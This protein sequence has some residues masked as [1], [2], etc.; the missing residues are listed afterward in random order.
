MADDKFAVPESIID[1]LP[2]PVGTTVLVRV[3]DGPNSRL[4]DIPDAVRINAA[5]LATIGKVVSLG[6]DAY[7]GEAFAS[8]PYCQPGDYVS[9]GKY[10]GT[11]VTVK[12]PDPPEG[13]KLPVG[14]GSGV[15]FRV[16]RDIDVNF[17]V[18]DPSAVIVDQ[19]QAS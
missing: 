16:I 2:R 19:R 13:Q 6:A 12:Y 10:A 8:G 14:M 4:L 18:P 7:S 5:Y 11:K 3:D 9:F 1:R 15:Q 17:V